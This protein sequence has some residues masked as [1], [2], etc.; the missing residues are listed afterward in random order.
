ML[1]IVQF[2]NVIQSV[3]IPKEGTCRKPISLYSVRIVHKLQNAVVGTE[4]VY[5]V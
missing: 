5:A 4:N 1:T 3:R 2:A